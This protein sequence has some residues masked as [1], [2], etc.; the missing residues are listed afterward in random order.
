[1]QVSRFGWHHRPLS[2]V[3]EMGREAP[4]PRWHV[5]CCVTLSVRKIYRG[6]SIGRG[7]EFSV[8]NR[9]R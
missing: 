9:G 8:D 1:M 6:L 3:V 5:P 7:I 4:G 2:Q